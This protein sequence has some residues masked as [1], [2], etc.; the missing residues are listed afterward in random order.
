MCC[1][2]CC[3][4]FRVF[5]CPAFFE[6]VCVIVVVCCV[7]FLCYCSPFLC[8]CLRA[9]CSLCVLD[10]FVLFCLFVCCVRFLSYVALPFLS[11]R[12]LLLILCV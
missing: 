4:R 11:V 8:V 9:C 7:R 6:C 10:L 12:V 5:C 3:V 1:F 2:E